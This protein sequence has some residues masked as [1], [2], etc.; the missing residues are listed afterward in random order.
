[1]MLND[2]D[3]YGFKIEEEVAQKARHN[4]FAILTRRSIRWTDL[5][6]NTNPMIRSK[7]LKR[8]I[9]KGIPLSLRREVWMK[10]SGAQRALETQPN[11]Y[12]ELLKRQFKAEIVEIIKIDL[13]RTFPDNIYFE[14][15]KMRLF[16]IL[17]AFAEQN[18]A[19]GYCQVMNILMNKDTSHSV[20]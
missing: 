15:Y 8:F 6:K 18:Q 2:V 4:Y 7:K 1:M 16:N 14:E 20:T 11:L 3:E 5:M 9:R 17:V 19:V 13:P 12:Q 10:C